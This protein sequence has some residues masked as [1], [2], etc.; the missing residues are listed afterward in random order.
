[1]RTKGSRSRLRR[2]P[3]VLA[4]LTLAGLW[5]SGCS[6][7]GMQTE[8]GE[9]LKQTVSGLSGTDDFRFTGTTNVSVGD[10]PM[11]EAA[12]FEGVVT[13]HNRL[14]MKFKRGAGTGAIGAMGAKSDAPVVFSRKQNEWVLAEPASESDAS[15]LLPWSPI[16]KLEQLNTMA[17]RVEGA[18]DESDRKLTVLTVTPEPGDVTESVKRQ[19]TRQSGMLDTDKKLSELRTK[20]G[21]SEAEA[22]RLKDELDRNV[23]KTKRQLDEAAGSLQASSVYRIWVG[24]VDRLPQKMQVETDMSYTVD[25]QPKR[26]KTRVDYQ[27]TGYGKAAGSA[28]KAE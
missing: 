15:L 3:A 17:K 8:P 23:Q 26:E 27:F 9:L 22:S 25:G 21:M 18:R 16:F 1:M 11:Q 14:S 13:G 7:T 5:S 24:R 20:L 4:V 19:L 10:R 28:E 6:I 12:A 2:L